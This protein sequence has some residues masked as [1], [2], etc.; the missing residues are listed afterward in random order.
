MAA[1]EEF[2]EPSLRRMLLRP[3]EERLADA[4]AEL[5]IAPPGSR[6]AAA[7]ELEQIRA[8]MREQKLL[9]R[10]QARDAARNALPREEE[11]M[12]DAGRAGDPRGAG[13]RGRACAPTWRGRG[14]YAR[15]HGLDWRPHAKTHKSPALAAEQ[16]RA[17]AVGVTVATPAEAEVMASAWTTSYSPTRRWA[18]SSS[19]RLMELRRRVRLTVGLDSAEA[20]SRPRRRLARAGPDDR[21]AGGDGLGHAPRGRADARRSGGAGRAPRQAEG[22]CTAG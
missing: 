11:P 4:S 9:E 17:G 2:F 21:R 5:E 3:F 7:E 12:T 19:G 16:V 14:G 13:G 18:R 22:I 1:P 10:A 15:E 6:G 8:T 20:P